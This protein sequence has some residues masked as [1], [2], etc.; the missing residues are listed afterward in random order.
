MQESTNTYRYG[1]GLHPDAG[2]LA[3]LT[4]LNNLI[5]NAIEER[6]QAILEAREAG[7]TWFQI[8]ASANLSRPAAIKYGK[9]AGLEVAK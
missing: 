3:R 2:E 5:N 9:R 4:Q 7:A 8:C 1:P 6:D